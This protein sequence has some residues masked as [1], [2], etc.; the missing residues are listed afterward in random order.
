[1]LV[2]KFQVILTMVNSVIFKL[3]R[4]F[5]Q[6]RSHP[7]AQYV[8]LYAVAKKGREV[9]PIPS[10]LAEPWGCIEKLCRIPGMML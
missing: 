6:G 4:I 1:M 9:R 8:N 2:V 3:F 10:G 7:E 5:G